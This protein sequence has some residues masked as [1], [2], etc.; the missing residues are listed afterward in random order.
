MIP[1]AIPALPVT[2]VPGLLLPAPLTGV[3]V[4]DVTAAVAVIVWAVGG[5]VALG[6]AIRMSRDDSHP[7]HDAS[8]LTPTTP[9]GLR[10]AA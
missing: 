5:L 4:I 9:H 7:E 8:H 3:S 6:F 1:A 10:D 2:L